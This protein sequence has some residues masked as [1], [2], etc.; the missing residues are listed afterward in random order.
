MPAYNAGKYIS[1][2]IR[3]VLNQSYTNWELIVINDGSTDDTEEKVLTLRA[4][5]KRIIYFFQKNAGQGNA[6]NQGLLKAKGA[7]IAFL[8]ADD[9]WVKDKLCI[10]VET[11]QRHP[12]IDLLFSGA[13]AFKESTANTLNHLNYKNRATYSGK[14]AIR[15][16]IKGNKVPILT[17][18]VKHEVITAVGNFE[19]SR[20]LQNVEDSHLWLKLLFGNFTLKSSEE[21]LAYYRIHDAQVTSDSFKNT[22]KAISLIKDFLGRDASIDQDILAEID[23]K[24]YKLFIRERSAP[25]KEIVLNHYSQHYRL[26]DKFL[27]NFLIN[28]LPLR[29]FSLYYRYIHKRWF[30]Q[31]KMI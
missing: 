12:E 21:V 1:E 27:F 5:N 6:R 10:Q 19:A 17:V 4:K 13:K 11:M 16:F 28:K 22:I 23:S 2:S 30:N 26:Q 9:L 29:A 31:Q 14:D 20:H 15:T 25:E 8:D 24:Y 18:L 7:Y 3:S